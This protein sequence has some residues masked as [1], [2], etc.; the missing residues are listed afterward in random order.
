MLGRVKML[1]ATGYEVRLQGNIDTPYCHLCQICFGNLVTFQHMGD[2]YPSAYVHVILCEFSMSDVFLV[3]A[4]CFW[5]L[6]QIILH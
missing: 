2:Q 5:A 3:G 6:F 1:S 4:V